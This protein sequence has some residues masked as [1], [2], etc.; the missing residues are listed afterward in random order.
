LIVVKSDQGQGK[1]ENIDVSGCVLWNELAHALSIGAEL[2]EDIGHVVFHDC[3]VVHDKGREWTLRIYNCDSARVSNVVFEDIRVA[4]SR[5]LASLWIG[6][7]VWSKEAERGHIE[8]VVFR[9][10]RV[11]S[12]TAQ[13]ESKGYDAGH[14]VDDALFENVTLPGGPLE[15]GEIG[16]NE[17]S[18][19]I[20][21]KP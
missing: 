20:E 11:A 3:D 13:V 17:F 5:R 2:R 21:V 15:V 16:Q 10:I 9:N 4:E 14:A 7:A 19:D 6:K 1:V 12:G 8:Q 18:R